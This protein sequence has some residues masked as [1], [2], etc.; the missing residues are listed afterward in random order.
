MAGA[1][2]SYNYSALQSNE[3]FSQVPWPTFDYHLADDTFTFTADGHFTHNGDGP[4]HRD[5]VPHA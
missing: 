3:T 2:L 1:L 5:D 4:Y